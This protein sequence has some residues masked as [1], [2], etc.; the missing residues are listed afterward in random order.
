MPEPLYLVVVNSNQR[1][2]S[3]P[4]QCSKHL[5]F[6]CVASRAVCSVCAGG[7]LAEE[8][9]YWA[10]STPEPLFGAATASLRTAVAAVVD[11]MAADAGQRS[12]IAVA[13][14]DRN[15]CKDCQQDCTNR[16]YVA[17]FLT[18]SP[19][20]SS[21]GELQRSAAGSSSFSEWR[22]NFGLAMMVSVAE[23]VAAITAGSG[24]SLRLSQ[25]PSAAYLERR[26]GNLQTDFLIS[27]VD[28]CYSKKT[29]HCCWRHCHRYYRCQRRRPRRYYS[30]EL[31]QMCRG[32]DSS[33]VRQELRGD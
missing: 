1:A 10:A 14:F 32:K 22:L 30:V 9:C 21:A 26:E 5:Q 29:R 15:S 20:D 6:L 11:W 7:C 18:R 8:A 31:L 24:C 19:V 17:G 13:D 12:A 3:L 2:L 33:V 4:W 23:F 27:S 25:L 28:Y 16:C